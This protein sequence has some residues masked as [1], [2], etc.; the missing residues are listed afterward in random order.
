MVPCRCAP[1]GEDSA[2]LFDMSFFQN[3]G[4]V[5]LWKEMSQQPDDGESEAAVR[6]ATYGGNSFDYQL[7][8]A[9]LHNVEQSCEA[10]LDAKPCLGRDVA[11]R[12][13]VS[14]STNIY[15]RKRTCLS[16]MREQQ[17]AGDEPRC[18]ECV[19]GPVHVVS[20][21]KSTVSTRPQE[22]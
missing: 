6:K 20:S 9:L 1:V 21:C 2:R 14:E 16:M 15:S 18:P 3:S 5:A 4:G 17:T 11:T 13:E 8:V 12:S 7:F 22:V 19:D 10:G